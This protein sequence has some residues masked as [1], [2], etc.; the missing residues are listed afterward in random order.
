MNQSI[1]L[2]HDGVETS[3]E[4]T[5][6]RHRKH[7]MF[8][9]HFENGYENIFFT[10]VET[11]EWIEEDFGATELAIE[12]GKQL[13]TFIQHPI[14]VPKLLTWHKQLIGD[15]LTSFGFYCFLKN[16]YRMYE[17]YSQSKKYLCTL[18]E[19]DNEEW[20]VLGGNQARLNHID[21]S[22]LNQVTH[23][24]PSYWLNVR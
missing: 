3:A 15:H 1:H 20:H 5:E 7:R 19:M 9:V 10:D 16:K 17:I 23:I 21:S 11:G 6:I 13:Q 8:R 24:L 4:I 22:F 12:V 18:V 14:H 2:I